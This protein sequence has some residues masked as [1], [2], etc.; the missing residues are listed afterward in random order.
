MS[1]DRFN[2]VEDKIDKVNDKVDKMDD[3]VDYVIVEVTEMRISTKHQMDTIR[4]HV[5][6]DQKIINHIQPLLPILEDLAEM[7]KDH[8][9]EKTKKEKSLETIKGISTRVGI[10]AGCIGIVTAISK[11]W[12]P[13]INLFL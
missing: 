4:Q 10:A 3:K 9:F 13:I 6:A 8:K 7:V 12:K 1:E 5:T 2:R 11:Y